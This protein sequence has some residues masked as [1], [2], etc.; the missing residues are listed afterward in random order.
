MNCAVIGLAGRLPRSDRTPAGTVTVTRVD[1]LNATAG[2][3]ISV[4]PVACQR[5]GTLGL[6]VGAAA[7]RPSGS[8]CSW[9]TCGAP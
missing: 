2:V 7:P 5:P 4:S 9:L 3:N 1:G 6:R 8:L